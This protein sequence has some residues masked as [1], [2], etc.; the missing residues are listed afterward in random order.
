M[1]EQ[2][3][4]I[5]PTPTNGVNV[6]VKTELDWTRNV[7][8]APTKIATY[9]VNQGTYGMS[10]FMNFLRRLANDPV[11]QNINPVIANIKPC[12]KIWWHAYLSI[13]ALVDNLPSRADLNILTISNRQTVS[14]NKEMTRSKAPIALSEMVGRLNKKL[15]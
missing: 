12:V 3:T 7:M 5:S 10:A 9:P 14:N 1:G 11:S 13:Y 8:I 15:Q 6:E 4:E 2:L